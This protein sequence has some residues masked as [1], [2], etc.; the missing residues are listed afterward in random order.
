MQTVKLFVALQVY[1][2]E[3]EFPRQ[4]ISHDATSGLRSW[5]W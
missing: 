2:P 1:L 5:S 3:Q 4:I